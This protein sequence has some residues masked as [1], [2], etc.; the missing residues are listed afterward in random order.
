MAHPPL[1]VPEVARARMATPLLPE[2]DRCHL[3][4]Y[5]VPRIGPGTGARWRRR[6]WL[7]SLKQKQKACH[8]SGIPEPSPL[9]RKQEKREPR[10]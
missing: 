6:Q 7:P 9:D 8:I 2:V 10:Q 4:A 1:P 5:A 3:H